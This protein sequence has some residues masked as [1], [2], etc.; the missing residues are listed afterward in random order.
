MS[1]HR[2]A[3]L[4]YKNLKK[5]Y[6]DGISD[7]IESKLDGIR[8]HDFLSPEEV[9]YSQQQAQKKMHLFEQN[10]PFG[11][12]LGINLYKYNFDADSYF[13][14]VRG[15]QEEYNEIFG[16][17]ILGRVTEVLSSVSSKRNVSV[18]CLSGV[19]G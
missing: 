12:M 16:F 17:D 11:K 15:A 2:W 4:S 10:V 5:E 1:L 9:E 8:V 14:S 19:C 7:L 3:H 13:N 6:P 18:G